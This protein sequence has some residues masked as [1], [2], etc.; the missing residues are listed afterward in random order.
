M[1]HLGLE[2]RN[3]VGKAEAGDNQQYIAFIEFSFKALNFIPD[4]TIGENGCWQ[5]W[6]PIDD[7]C[8]L[9]VVTSPLSR[10]SARTECKRWDWTG[11]VDLA[12]L[13]SYGNWNEV[14]NLLVRF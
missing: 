10:N 2:L 8:Y 6:T 4:T 9:A 12:S 3:G 13:W 5:G 11:D 14:R 7:T 1:F